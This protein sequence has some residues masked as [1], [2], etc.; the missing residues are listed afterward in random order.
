MSEQKIALHINKA[1]KNTKRR[2]VI[3]ALL[4]ITSFSAASLLLKSKF[5]QAEKSILIKSLVG[6]NTELLNENCIFNAKTMNICRFTH[7]NYFTPSKLF[8]R[9]LASYIEMHCAEIALEIFKSDNNVF[10]ATDYA[11]P[12][13]SQLLIKAQTNIG[14]NFDQSNLQPAIKEFIQRG[15]DGA[16]ALLNERHNQIIKKFVTYYTGSLDM[17]QRTGYKAIPEHKTDYNVLD[18]RNPVVL[19]ILIEELQKYTHPAFYTQ[20]DLGV[21]QITNHKVTITKPSRSSLIIG[22]ITFGLASGL[23]FVLL[24]HFSL[25]LFQ[26]IKKIRNER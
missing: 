3:Y 12:L 7:N 1:I 18:E 2:H 10:C 25:K 9:F 21:E 8:F 16:I 23:F 6:F 20:A 11:G 4:F 13:D 19:R 14:N 26:H 17:W 24:F 15:I 5:H 22:G